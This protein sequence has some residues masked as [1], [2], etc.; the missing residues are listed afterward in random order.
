MTRPLPYPTPPRL[1]GMESSSR[2]AANTISLGPI[3]I[4]W[5]LLY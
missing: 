1:F 2:I 4:G 3:F 5:W